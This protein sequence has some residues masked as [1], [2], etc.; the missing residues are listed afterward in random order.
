MGG[1]ANE[2]STARKWPAAYRKKSEGTA[3]CEERGC[4]DMSENV[5]L[6]RK[7]DEAIAVAIKD[8]ASKEVIVRN[9][10]RGDVF[11]EKYDE[12]ND[13]NLDTL[14]R[15]LYIGYEVEETPEEKVREFYRHHYEFGNKT[16]NGVYGHLEDRIKYET[17]I[18]VLEMLNIKIEGVNT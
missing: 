18:E 7:V 1:L 10:A 14:I 15:A 9:K 2:Q 3:A 11:P 16:T 5:K 12:L 13:V 4:K 8:Y 6:S 17:V